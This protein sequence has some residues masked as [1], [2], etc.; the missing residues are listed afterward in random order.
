MLCRFALKLEGSSNF[1]KTATQFVVENTTKLMTATHNS[2]IDRINE[3]QESGNC[4]LKEL[5]GIINNTSSTLNTLSTTHS[6][7]NIFQQH[8]LVKARPIKVGS[9]VDSVVFNGKTVQKSVPIVY[10]YVPIIEK[11]KYV[12]SNSKIKPLIKQSKPAKDGC[13]YSFLDGSKYTPVE[14]ELHLSLSLYCDDIEVANPLGAKSGVHKLS[15]YYFSVINLPAELLSST[16]HIHLA[17]VAMSQDVKLVGN[18]AIL[19]Q[20][21]SDL[22]TLEAGVTVDGELVRATLAVIAADNLAA[23][24]LLN[25]TDSFV[26]DHCCRFCTLSRADM[27]TRC[28]PPD[29]SVLR[30][31]K[32]SE[33]NVFFHLITFN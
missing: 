26:A 16:S 33:F 31:K 29:A 13:L 17:A 3:M 32:V 28:D 15:M 2:L 9:R 25:M 23:N 4:N 7:Y 11:I 14:A 20:L 21:V 19:S 8:G 6:R 22:K 10:Q 5:L 18:N 12:L 30:T 1:S 27:Q 24:S